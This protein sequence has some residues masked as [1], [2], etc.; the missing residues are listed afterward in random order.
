MTGR[1]RTASEIRH[2]EVRWREG[3][4]PDKGQT[5]ISIERVREC[6][7]SAKFWTDTLGPYA[8]DMDRRADRYALISVA[9]STITGL[10]VWSTLATSTQLPAVLAVSAVAFA[11]AI[12]AAVPKTIGYADCA[13][14]A[15]SLSTDYG[16]IYGELCDAHE[17]LKLKDPG[18]QATASQAVGLFEQIR[19]RKQMLKPFPAKLAALRAAHINS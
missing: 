13:K 16:D 8:D 17:L 12:V 11:S 6:K 19:A 1:E 5:H 4:M 18:A 15:R 7:A 9:L 10:A 3:A 14:A 2:G